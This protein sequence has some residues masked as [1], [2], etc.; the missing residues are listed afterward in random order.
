MTNNAYD[1][2]I[3]NTKVLNILMDNLCTCTKE[4]IAELA[5]KQLKRSHSAHKYEESILLNAIKREKKKGMYRVEDILNGKDFIISP[6]G[7]KGNL[8]II[9]CFWVLQ[10]MFKDEYLNISNCFKGKNPETMSYSTDNITYA[11]YYITEDTLGIIPKSIE[12]AE[13]YSSLSAKTRDIKY[14]LINIY[15][16]DSI[17]CADT[18]TEATK[19]IRC[20]IAITKTE[21]SP[22]EKPL[23]IAYIVDGNRVK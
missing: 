9:P 22:Y 10:D 23:D 1:V 17:E 15:V 5:K 16:T 12:R 14:H 11:F 20:Q 18:I 21:K 19:G 13:L 3:D 8:S 7:E 4:Q 2:K 6:F